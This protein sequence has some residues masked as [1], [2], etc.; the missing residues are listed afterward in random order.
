MANEEQ[1]TTFKEKNGV[2][3]SFR[4]PMAAPW[5]TDWRKTDS[6]QAAGQNGFH[7]EGACVP[8]ASLKSCLTFAN[9]PGQQIQADPGL[10]ERAVGHGI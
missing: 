10:R 8:S 6:S 9:G 2:K 3:L 7:G 1:S 5:W 4:W